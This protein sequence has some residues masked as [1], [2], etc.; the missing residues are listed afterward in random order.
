MKRAVAILGV[1]AAL[2]IVTVGAAW[3]QDVPDPVAIINREPAWRLPIARNDFL[4]ELVHRMG[5]YV[6]KQLALELLVG[7]RAQPANI[8][9]TDDEVEARVEQVAEEKG[10]RN[11]SRESAY[12]N[13]LYP[14]LDATTAENRWREDTRLQLLIE[15]LV[16]QD[17]KV[18]DE[19]AKTFWDNYQ[20]TS[21]LI[22]R[23]EGRRVSIMVIEELT[24]AKKARETVIK[25]PGQWRRICGGN[26]IDP[27]SKSKGGDYGG[28]VRILPGQERGKFEKEVFDLK[29]VGDISDVISGPWGFVIIRLDEI[30]PAKK[31]QFEEA[32]E[33]IRD[34]LRTLL[35]R[36]QAQIWMTQ[37]AWKDVKLEVKIDFE[38][39]GGMPAADPVATINSQP[40]ARA[41][42]M[43]ELLRRGGPLVLRQ[44]VLEAVIRKRGEEAGVQ[45]TDEEV[46]Q[47][48][49]QLADQQNLRS[50]ATYREYLAS[51]YPG[52][53]FA[54]AQ[55]RLEE[56]T[57]LQV[58]V[59]KIVA[60]QKIEVTDTEVS[61]FYDKYKDTSPLLS[62]PEGR[63]VS[64][65]MTDDRAQADKAL[66]A[67]RASPQSWG[68]V[69]RTYSQDTFTRDR[70]GDFG[71]YLDKPSPGEQADAFLKEVFRLSKPG[72]IGEV[73]VPPWGG[74]V[75]AR[76]DDI[77]PPQK[78]EYSDE[79]KAV[80]SA[81]LLAAKI[82][83][84]ASKWVVQD[85][86]KDIKLDV[87]AKLGDR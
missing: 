27:I 80:I 78:L 63:R 83:R 40:L 59:E 41:D 14:G 36:R 85:A 33:A 4:H 35:I 64:V 16:A 11:P 28:Y 81:Q 38:A 69:C 25:A 9:V 84:A 10:L 15:K 73:T 23:P 48:I 20:D 79:T 24:D 34:S 75:I 82:Q 26:S 46:R 58:M 6:L 68:E 30:Q 3:G 71:R 67:L 2:A 37:T 65:I 39:E 43:R 57:R 13:G 22:N 5:P 32:K 51:V 17:V 74:Y 72:E 55:E 44:L 31:F 86:W 52:L 60:T 66:A 47:A 53:E 77:R 29:R 19:E 49:Q 12:L 50:M 8:T 62:R 45:V 18:T 56:D 61:D 76:L 1:L 21:P 42:F 70:A 87:K 54:A 7:Q